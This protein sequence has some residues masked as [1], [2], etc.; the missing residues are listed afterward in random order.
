MTDDTKIP[1]KWAFAL[2]SCSGAGI[3]L[4]MSAML[5]IS[6][7]AFTAQAAKDTAKESA[8]KT[9]SYVEVLHKI[10]LRLSNLEGALGVKHRGASSLTGTR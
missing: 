7:V 4:A 10:D 6:N 8:E 2:L 1:L 9:A 3:I 5:W